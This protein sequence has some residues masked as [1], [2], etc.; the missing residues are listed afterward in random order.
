[1]RGG[2]GNGFTAVP[3][4]CLAFFCKGKVLRWLE[5]SSLSKQIGCNCIETISFSAKIGVTLLIGSGDWRIGVVE[6]DAVDGT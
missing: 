4:T 1:M 6:L 3:V 2:G 5:L